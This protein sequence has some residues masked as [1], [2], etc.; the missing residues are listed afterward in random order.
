MARLLYEAWQEEAALEAL[1]DKIRQERELLEQKQNFVRLSSHYL[2]TPLTL[3]NVGIEEMASLGANALLISQLQQVGNRLNL[4][5]NGMLEQASPQIAGAGRPRQKLPNLTLYLAGSLA[6]AFIVIASAVYLLGHLD[7]SNFKFNSL[8]AELV[9]VLLAGVLV[10]SIWRTR[11]ARRLVKKH[12]EELL[13]EQ[14][15]LDKER[16][17]VVKGSL[18]NLT[19]P[20]EELKMLLKPLS[21]QPMAGPVING[22]GSFESI[23]RRFVILS[24]LETGLMSTQKAVISLN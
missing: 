23:L 22:L 9:V 19:G 6:G 12:F 16:N 17:L 8:L 2:R 15:A 7:L 21:R 20:L 11:A 5:V 14:R 3:V 4:G 24:S 18:D 1:A 10:Y 13:S